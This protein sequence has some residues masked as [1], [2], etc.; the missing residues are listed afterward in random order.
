MTKKPLVH[1]LTVARKLKQP[2]STVESAKALANSIAAS[3]LDVVSGG[4]DALVQAELSY[5]AARNMDKAAMLAH[6][7]MMDEWAVQMYTF[8]NELKKLRRMA[9]LMTSESIADDKEAGE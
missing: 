7:D 1:K 6:C 3:A 9:E 4:I 5:D 2:A 8:L